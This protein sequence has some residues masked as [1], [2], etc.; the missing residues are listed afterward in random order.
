MV[1]LADRMRNIVAS[2]RENY[3]DTMETSSRPGPTT[4][5]AIRSLKWCKAKGEDCLICHDPMK[6][7]A[8]KLPCKHEFHAECIIPWLKITST[9]PVCRKIVQKPNC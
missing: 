9:C 3:V 4:K 1:T 8:K 6:G 7:K 2:L 5:E